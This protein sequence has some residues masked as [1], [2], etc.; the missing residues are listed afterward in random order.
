MRPMVALAVAVLL[1]GSARADNPQAQ[2]ASRLYD[3][4]EYRESGAA[5]QRAYE[6]DPRPDSLYGW[7]QATRMA[8]DCQTA[9]PLYRKFLQGN[10]PA[11][12]A[13][14][15]RQNLARC[16]ENEPAQPAPTQP[17]PP[18]KPWYKDVAGAALS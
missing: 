14:A 5:Y 11:A 17:A 9:V 18:M 7:A 6:I 16:V 10:P 2:E 13:A 4:K 3:A 12:H 1:A 15:A 8:G